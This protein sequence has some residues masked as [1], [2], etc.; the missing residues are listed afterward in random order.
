MAKASRTL[1]VPRRLRNPQRRRSPHIRT[2]LGD[3]HDDGA[4]MPTPPTR[5]AN[6]GPLN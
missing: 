4:I 6:G 3:E 5:T 1:S 2:L